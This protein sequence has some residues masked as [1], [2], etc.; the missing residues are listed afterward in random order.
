MLIPQAYSKAQDAGH[1]LEVVYVPVADSPEVGAMEED[2]HSFAY[3]FRHILREIADFCSVGVHFHGDTFI[4]GS[5]AKGIA[6]F[7]KR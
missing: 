2:T 5:T 7:Q 3:Y 1:G 4:V 6:I